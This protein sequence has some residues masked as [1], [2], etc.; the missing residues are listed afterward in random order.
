MPPEEFNRQD[1]FAGQLAQFKSNKKRILA[2]QDVCGICGKPVDKNL[3]Y[4]HPLSATVDCMSKLMPL[5]P[6]QKAGTPQ[7]LQT[8]NWRTSAATGRSPTNS[9]PGSNLKP[10]R[11]L[12]PTASCLRRSTGKRSEQS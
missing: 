6:W 12:S 9:A 10:P 3:K 7:T 8:Y 2:T 4:P 11:K 5:S 1:K